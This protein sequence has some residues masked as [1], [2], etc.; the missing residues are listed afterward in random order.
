MK[1]TISFRFI[2]M[3]CFACASL[4]GC[5]STKDLAPGMG[6]AICIH[7]RGY[8]EVW[9]AGMH[10]VSANGMDIEEANRGEGIIRASSGSYLFRSF[11]GYHVIGVFINPPAKAADIYTLEV[12]SRNVERFALPGKD[13]EPVI[14]ENVQE[15]LPDTLSMRVRRWAWQI[16]TRTDSLPGVF[17][18]SL[19]GTALIAVVDGMRYAIPVDSIACI[20]QVRPRKTVS[21]IVVGGSLGFMAGYGLSGLLGA[22]SLV[23][24]GAVG[25]LLGAVIGSAFG[26]DTAY[27]LAGM[28]TQRHLEEVREI[29]E[30]EWNP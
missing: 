8:D 25:I 27:E 23:A 4:I 11:F 16:V 12:V 3:V 15:R 22:L 20:R 10:A 28:D 29:L 18:E 24:G 5:V 17:L 7:G 26:G 14:I 2:A 19:D 30:D 13:W 9:E 21:G 6:T 1:N